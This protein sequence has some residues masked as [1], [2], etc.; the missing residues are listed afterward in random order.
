MTA[1]PHGRSANSPLTHQDD[2]HLKILIASDVSPLHI[3]G[4]GERVLREHASRLSAR[5]H[6]VWVVSRSTSDTDPRQVQ[7]D[8]F[9]LLHYPVDRRSFIRFLHTS[10]FGARDAISVTARDFRPDILHLYQP[11]SGFGAF[12]SGLGGHIPVL[13]TFLSPAP[14][15]Y[16]ARLGM[17]IRHR[18][19]VIGLL[20]FIFLWLIERSCL[21]KAT[22]IHVL[23][24]F[25][26]SQLWQLYRIPSNRIVKIPGGVDTLRFCPADDR[27][28]IRQSLGLPP[29]GPLLLTIRNL[30]DRMGLD[31]L[32]N[33][34]GILRTCIPDVLLVIG[35]SGSL[36]ASL[37]SLSQSLG[38]QNHI[39]F[40]GYILED[41]LPRYYQAADVF[42]LPTRALEGF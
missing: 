42:V 32:I 1:L 6:E 38:L 20:G 41:D 8:G 22:Q 33:A 16:R 15:E 23:S 19:G 25:S 39:R 31:V 34:M 35:G 30:E 11:L 27:S 26:A 17:S 3:E 7:L 18:G 28:A 40:S 9:T 14:L 13:Y 36:R 2:S 4:G 12:R 5:G 21:R 10:I 29:G 24:D 37:E